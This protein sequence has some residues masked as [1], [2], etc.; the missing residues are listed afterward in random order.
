MDQKPTSA[1]APSVG[2]AEV[3]PDY[4]AAD[5]LVV[6]EPPQL[7]ALADDLRSRI[8]ILLREHARS[9]TELAERLGLPKGTVGHHV[10]VLERA[11][12]IRV[13]RTRQVRAVTE[14]YYGR[15]ARLFL[16]ESR[17]GQSAEDV[18]DIVA[19][20]LR[21]AADEIMPLN[22]SDP[23]AI[24]C[25]GVLRVRLDAADAARFNRRLDRLLDEFRKAEDPRGQP[26]GL[27]VALY[28][29]SPDA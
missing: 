26:Y 27:A 25:S 13:V 6:R 12:L 24:A 7:K 8:V 17:D 3:G 23:D 20:S 9:T 5:V 1:A 29:R 22:D 2:V 15:T 11:G 16:Y 10:K 18:R 19:A 21:V 14:K 28:K 4:D